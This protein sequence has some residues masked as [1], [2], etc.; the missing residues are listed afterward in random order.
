ML[1]SN[2]RKEVCEVLNGFSLFL[3]KKYVGKKIH[4]M[5]FSMLDPRFKNR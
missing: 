5:L 3:K 4:N 1:A 2:I